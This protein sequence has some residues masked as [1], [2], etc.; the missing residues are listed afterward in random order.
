[1]GGFPTP[2]QWAAWQLVGQVGQEGGC[3]PPPPP[4]WTHLVTVPT[5][6]KGKLQRPSPTP[7]TLPRPQSPWL[8]RG[9]EHGSTG[10]LPVMSA[11]RT[12]WGSEKCS[13]P[14]RL[15]G[16]PFWSTWPPRLWP[17]GPPPPAKTQRGRPSCLQPAGRCVACTPA[18]MVC[19]SLGP[20]PQ[21]L[22][23]VKPLP[24]PSSSHRT[25]L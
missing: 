23:M 10:R 15:I 19:F 5:G 14:G 20:G 12:V 4:R 24:G 17:P 3:C 1:M 22:P 25:V 11:F 18:D 21:A 6:C 7:F 8:H 13:A 16:A 9:D 2:S